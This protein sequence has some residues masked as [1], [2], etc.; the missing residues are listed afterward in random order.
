[1]GQR[2]GRLVIVG[3]R[4]PFPSLFLRLGARPRGLDRDVLRSVGGVRVAA[5]RL[6]V[7]VPHQLSDGRLAAPGLGE[8]SAEG[9]T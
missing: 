5:R 8:P 4:A 6:R 2:W 3:L 7:G 1:L 9:M